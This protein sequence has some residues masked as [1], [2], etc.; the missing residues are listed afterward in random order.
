MWEWIIAHSSVLQA[1][2]G[3]ITAGIW[4]TYLQVFVGSMRRHRRSE[5]LITMGGDRGI[6]GR[7]LISNLGLEPIYI[8]DVL[9]KNYRA[10][11]DPAISVVDRTETDPADLQNPIHSTLQC[12]L[13][14]GEYVDLGSFS[15][16]LDRAA[17][18]SGRERDDLELSQIEITVAAVTAAASTIVAARRRFTVAVI[19]DTVLLRPVSLYATQI[20]G[21][22]GRRH[23]QRLLRNAM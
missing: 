4:I 10:A 18:R 6:G 13:K 15:N 16:V 20:R 21:W 3:L 17:R 22:L 19:E 1:L 9:F 11:D 7:V 5:I 14:S 2:V 8:L 23:V 12:P